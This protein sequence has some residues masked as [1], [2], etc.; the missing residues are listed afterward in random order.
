M[1]EKE[2]P[3]RTLDEVQHDPVILHVHK[4]TLENMRVVFENAGFQFAVLQFEYDARQNFRPGYGEN[5]LN[6]CKTLRYRDGSTDHIVSGKLK[7]ESEHLTRLII[8]LGS[9]KIIIQED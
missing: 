3:E 7:D 4:G 2:N 1:L 5:G 9:Q 8:E 6:I